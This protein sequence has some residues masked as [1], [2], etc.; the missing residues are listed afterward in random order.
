MRVVLSERVDVVCSVRYWERGA[1]LGGTNTSGLRGVVTC[2]VSRAV[3][4]EGAGA[5]AVPAGLRHRRGL[6]QRVPPPF[7]P[8][9]ALS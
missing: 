2:G 1:G 8:T 7:P 3:L 6:A 9:P 4:S 5:D